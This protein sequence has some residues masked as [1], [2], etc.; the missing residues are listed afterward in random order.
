MQA[1]VETISNLERR[2]TVAMPAQPIEEEIGKR[3]NTLART[4]KMAGFRPGKVPKNIV[5][6]QYG[7]QVRQEVM[8]AKVEETFGQAV[9]QH[10]LRVAGY[11]SI[12]PKPVEGV[13]ESYEYVATFEV[14]PEVKIGDLSALKIEHP[15]VKLTEADVNKTVDV[16]R[17]QRATYES[18]TRAAKMDDRVS[19]E[20]SSTIDGNKV[21]DTAGQTL[22]MTLGEGG[23]LPE[24]D[25]NIVG[26][27]AGKSKQFDLDF[28]ADYHNVDLAGKTASYDVKVVSVLAAQL[29]EV[30]AAF[31]K[32]LGVADGNVEKM[33]AD[34][35]ESLEQEIAK[36]VK[37]VI[38]QQVMDGLVGA[39]ELELPRALVAL[40]SNNQLQTAAQNLQ[41]RG[42]SPDELNLIPSMFEET[43]KRTVKLRMMMME[44]V[45]ANSLQ[46]TPEQVRAQI[47]EF[48]Q[49]F[50][51]PDEVVTWYFADPKRLD[52]PSAMAT[53]EN[54]VNWVLNQAK[55]SDKK[56]SFDDLMGKGKD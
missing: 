8:S 46:A 30:D 55:V 45:R 53:E 37:A 56:T 35:Q 25:A 29:P 28:P 38:K 12:A 9:M 22:D 34:I 5:V 26:I 31:A 27:K 42:L 32:E 44:I 41:Q 11:P 6:Q 36:R 54:V 4:A 15:K 24:F 39:V 13:P 3:L 20:I 40:E 43:A 52:E 48:A 33:R 14:M 19:I 51:Q 2:L 23:R 18:V 50:E 16:L 47:N 7:D 17:R 49:N 10:Q 1:T 21:E